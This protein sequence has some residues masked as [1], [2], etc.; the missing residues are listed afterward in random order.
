MA[1]PAVSIAGNHDVV[2]C[3]RSRLT[4]GGLL[5]RDG[6]AND[7][8]GVVVGCRCGAGPRQRTEGG[9]AEKAKQAVKDPDNCGYPEE[10][11]VLSFEDGDVAE[12]C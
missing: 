2:K 10:N 5:N 1:L 7:V 6:K 9:D 11:V 12:H 4:E 8:C 3:A